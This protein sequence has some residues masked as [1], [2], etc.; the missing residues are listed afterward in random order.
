MPQGGLSIFGAGLQLQPVSPGVVNVGNFNLGGVG[1]AR[2][3]DTR[4]AA[5]VAQENSYFGSQK[6][7]GVADSQGSCAF[8]FQQKIGG[9]AGFTPQFVATFGSGA[10]VYGTGGIAIGNSAV[11]GVDRGNVNQNNPHIAIGRNTVATG[12]SGDFS[13]FGNTAVG[14]ASTAVGLRACS[15]GWSVQMNGAGNADV[16]LIGTNISGAAGGVV[17]CLVIRSGAAVRNLT[18]A[19]DSHSIQIG[20]PT[21]TVVRIGPYTID[22]GLAAVGFTMTGSVT[23]ANTAAETSIV[24]TVAGSTSIP[25]NRLV[26]GSTIRI[27]ARGTIAST[28]TPT[29]RFRLKIGAN[30]FCDTLAT[31]LPVLAGTHGWTLDAD[32]TVRSA[33]AGG[34]ALGNMF[35]FVSVAAQPDLDTTNTATTPI[36][37]TNANAVDLTIQWGTANP[38]NTATCT[39]MTMEILG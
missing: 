28:G 15:F 4:T 1:I 11:A 16:I 35:T 8:G 30:T 5:T 6:S 10:Q 32:V 33:G 36:D 24:G 17:D 25:A 13:A 22:R 21:Q 23:V 27:R 19:A 20:E 7:F 37:T 34:G 12:D 9:A 26:A 2:T 3:F 29:I 14:S 39:N 31:A 38:A 18:A